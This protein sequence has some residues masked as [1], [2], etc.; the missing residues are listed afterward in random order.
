M[1]FLSSTIA[2]VIMAIMMVTNHLPH[3]PIGLEIFIT[4]F[5]LAGAVALATGLASDG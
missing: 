4:L 5:A 1:A 2:T 3:S